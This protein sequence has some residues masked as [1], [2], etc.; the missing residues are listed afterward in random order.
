[1]S[2]VNLGLLLLLSFLWGCSFYFIEKTLVYFS[3]EQVVFFRVL[4][5]SITIWLFLITKKVKFDLR[6]KLWLSFALMG[7]L[8]N[9]IPFLSFAYA[10]E[11]ISASY[12]SIINATTPIFTAVFAHLL[13]KDEKLTRAKL[14]GVMIGFVGIVVLI[15]PEGSLSLDQHILIAM[16]APISYAFAGI[17]GKILKGV[18]P[19]FAVFGMLFSSTVIMYVVFHTNI[20][21]TRVEHFAQFTDL[22]LLAVFSTAVAYIIYFRLLFS[23]GALKVSLVTF[24]IPISAS[25]LGVF[26]LGD[27]FTLNMYIGAVAVFL[28]L[29]LII[30]DKKEKLAKE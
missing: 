25:L 26:L 5:A 22:I 13:T 1:M 28:A 27:I 9:V 18:N 15:L 6:L 14:L 21:Q 8:N 3:F 10:Q 19:L 11:G 24:L 17:F 4:F 23:A 12:A 30:K 7:L 16:I 29:F 2:V 20:N